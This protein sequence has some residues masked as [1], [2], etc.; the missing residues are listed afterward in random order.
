MRASLESAGLPGRIL[1]VNDGSTD[2]S[3]KVLA[4]LQAD[5]IT[6]DLNRGYGA[7]IKTGILHAD[8]DFDPLEEALGLEVLR[9]KAPL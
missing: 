2:G 6:L 7:A 5:V 4:E 9:P 1:Y 3:G 8:T